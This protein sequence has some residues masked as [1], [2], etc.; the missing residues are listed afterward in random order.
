MNLSDC[1]KALPDTSIVSDGGQ[2]WLVWRLLEEIEDGEIEDIDG[3][4]MNEDE[5]GNA[6]IV[7]AS[8]GIIKYKEIQ[9]TRDN[10]IQTQKDMCKSKHIPL[11]ARDKCHI[12]GKCWADHLSLIHI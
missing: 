11:F 1:L 7:Y 12:C 6:I 9:N 2:N 3:Y 5:Q 4:I 8:T 10:R